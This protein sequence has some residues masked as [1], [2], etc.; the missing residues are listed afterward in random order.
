MRFDVSRVRA[1][2]MSIVVFALAGPAAAEGPIFGPTSYERTTG[3]P[4]VYTDTFSAPAAG[5]H[6]LWVQNGDDA[7]S[8]VSSGSIDVNGTLVVRESDFSRQVELLR[9]PVALLAGTNTITVTLNGEPGSFITVLILP[10][11]ERPHMTVGRLLLPH[12]SATNLVLDL[13]NGSHGAARTV[14]IVFYDDAGTPVASSGRLLL[15]PR[16]SFSQSVGALMAIGSWTEGSIE[17]FY[18]GRGAGRVFG[19]AVP[20]D[21]TTGIGSIVPLQHAGH[22]HHPHRPQR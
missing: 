14:R 7:G 12:A 2:F 19:Q 5:Y 18:A 20:T 10:I 16:A 4:N 1:W 13:K 8:R 21:P 9:R 22:R 3:A 17:V 15:A 6:A 11:R